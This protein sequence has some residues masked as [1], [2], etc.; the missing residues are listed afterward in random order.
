MTK[1][2]LTI[3]Y[4]SIAYVSLFII[5]FMSSSFMIAFKI[6]G[7]GALIAVFICAFIMLFDNLGWWKKIEKF[8]NSLC[9][10]L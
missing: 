5:L 9:Q 10:E 3:M 6:M 7:M 8:L 4:G 1:R 2:Q